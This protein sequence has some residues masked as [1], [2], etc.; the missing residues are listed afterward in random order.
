MNY[1]KKIIMLKNEKLSESLAVLTLTKNASGVFGNLK[2]YNLSLKNAIIAICANGKSVLKENIVGSKN[3]DF[4]LDNN[5]DIN[6]KIGSVVAV[7][8]NE[9][10]V[11][12]VWGTNDNFVEYKNT[13]MQ[14]FV[15]PYKN[16]SKQSMAKIENM[17]NKIE[18]TPNKIEEYKTI[19][20]QNIVE[21]DEV[22]PMDE[23]EN[24]YFNL[25]DGEAYAKLFDSTPDEIEK[26]IDKE[27]EEGE[28]Y[29]L[30][31]DQIEELKKRY[32]KE[33]YLESIIPNSEWI[34][35]DFENE[36]NSYVVGLI[37]DEVNGRVKYVCYGVPSD[38][39]NI[40][41]DMMGYSQWI[42]LDY[43][44]E[45]GNGYYIMYQDAITGEPMKITE[46]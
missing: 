46:S 41:Q 34:R 4:K 17:P 3:F 15:E 22:K 20:V 39:E 25:K 31:A 16:L 1:F 29:A 33:Q 21:D 27:I 45:T 12:V 6:E 9:R 28:F 35:V 2:F 32:P 23:I 13:I 11:S 10:Y 44:N 43:N 7:K 40:P 26:T 42:P 30:I 19:N 37:F 5:L 24:K 8:E 18:D 14:S 36:G 38:Y